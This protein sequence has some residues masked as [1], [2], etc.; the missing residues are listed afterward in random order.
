M[1]ETGIIL[2][3]IRSC[4]SGHLGSTECS[5][6]FVLGGMALAVV[7]L[8]ITLAALRINHAKKQV[9]GQPEL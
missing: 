8:V 7:M 9:A 3:F 6:V 1:S 2:E 5:P 4:S